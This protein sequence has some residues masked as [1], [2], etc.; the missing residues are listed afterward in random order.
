MTK[1]QIAKIYI[2]CRCDVAYTS[3]GLSA[4]DCPYHSTDPEMAMEEWAKQQAIA[5]VKYNCPDIKF[6]DI[7]LNAGYTGFLIHQQQ[8]GNK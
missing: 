3:R 2:P 1:E 8:T 5:F 6:D 7:L 4:P